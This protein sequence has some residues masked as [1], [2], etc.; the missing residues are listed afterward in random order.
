MNKGGTG[1]MIESQ[2]LGLALEVAR[3]T[4]L[5]KEINTLAKEAQSLRVGGYTIN[6]NDRLET[7]IDLTNTEESNHAQP[8]N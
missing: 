8:A 4:A 2:A 3:L 6:A 5:V 1:I 7:I